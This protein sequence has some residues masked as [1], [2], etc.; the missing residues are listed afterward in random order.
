MVITIAVIIMRKMIKNIWLILCLLLGLIIAVALVS[1]IPV[2]GNGVL[3][4]MLVR[5]MEDYQQNIGSY[6]GVCQ[7]SLSFNSKTDRKDRYGIFDRLDGYIKK[8]VPELLNIPYYILVEDMETDLYSLYP[9]DPMK[10]DPTPSRLGKLKALSDFEKHVELSDG[11][12][13]SGKKADGVYEALVTEGA[14]GKF[15][16]ILGNTFIMRIPVEGGEMHIKVRPVGVFTPKET[17]DLY[18]TRA[19]SL[20]DERFYINQD[21]FKSDFASKDDMLVK[22]CEW[23]YALDYHKVMV[24]DINRMLKSH[25]IMARYVKHIYEGAKLSI[26]M[27][28]I[29]K[30]YT[31]QQRRISILLLSLNIPVILMLCFYLLMVSSLIIDMDRNEIALLKSRG[32]ARWHIVVQYFFE[33]VILSSIALLTGPYLGLLLTR[34]LGASRGFMESAGRKALPLALDITAYYY[35]LSAIC[36]FVVMLLVPAYRASAVTIITYKQQLARDTGTVWWKKV[37]IDFLLIFIAVYGIYSFKQHKQILDVTGIDAIDID[38]NP[39]LFLASTFF[40]LGMGLLFIRIYPWLLNGIYRAGR[41]WW[42]PPLYEVL[43]RVGRSLQKYQFIMIFLIMTL[44]TGLFSA[45][46]ARTLNSNTDARI[47]YST[48]SDINLMPVWQFEEVNQQSSTAVQEVTSQNQQPTADKL[49]G[50]LQNGFI[51]YI[52]PPFESFRQLPQVSCAAKVYRR[53]NVNADSGN[54]YT[55]GVQLIAVDPY[56][57]GQVAWFRGDLLKPYHINDYLN[58]L[59]DDPGAVLISKSFSDA[60][61]VK[62]GDYISIGWPGVNSADF[63]VYGII[64]YWP[65]WNPVRNRED[66]ENQAGKNE[67]S[68]MLVVANLKYVQEQLALEPYE[69]WLKLKPGASSSTL[70]KDIEQKGLSVEN[71]MDANQE[72]AKMKNMPLYLGINGAGTLA[73]IIAIIITFLGFM[74]YWILSVKKRVLE[75]GVM[76]AMGISTAKLV[77]MLVWEQLLT[78]VTAA[79]AGIFAGGLTSR[80]FVPF[81]QLAYGSAANVPPFRVVSEY[82]DRL[83]LYCMLCIMF[84]AGFVILSSILMKIKISQ[85]IK[86]GED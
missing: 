71:L 85:V 48:G 10:V 2:Y 4:K 28:D 34:L 67:T 24:Y 86:L 11:K 36:V 30:K 40:V 45:D 19:S 74:I 53:E 7:F 61:K 73:F 20:Y 55:D 31:L 18:W 15:K 84:A 58:L 1:S 32:A 79:A 70:Y 52:E 69:I 41:R 37:F 42:P 33:G 51:Q 21:L 29:L 76:R 22:S 6:P 12:M 23:Y 83:K 17:G 50:P 78:S 14:L 13:P 27:T 46:T 44:A 16:M 54:Y 75:F 35:A 26:P 64:N 65:S 77:G 80:L 60:G 62:V 68:P 49:K 59:A 38:I 9:E 66:S 3:Q 5:E 47:R 56:D 72:V 82:N 39:L 8:N 81:F 43:I 25:D 63:I 57:F